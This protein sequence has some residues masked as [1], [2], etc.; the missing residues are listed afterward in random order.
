MVQSKRG[1]RSV[2]GPATAPYKNGPYDWDEM[3]ALQKQSLPF[4]RYELTK[5]FG[6]LVALNATMDQA[7][8]V[9]ALRIIDFEFELLG[10]N[11]SDAD[12]T[13][14]ATVAGIQ[15]QTDGG[16]TDSI[17]ILP[18]LDTS[19]SPWATVLW[20]TENQ[21]I[22]ECVLHT[23]ANIA[24]VVIWAGLK[25]TNTDVVITDNDQVYFRFDTVVANWEATTSIGGV[26]TETDTGVAVAINTTYYLKI[27]IDSARL[28]HFY[29]NNKEVHTTAALTDD[30]DLIPY[31]GILESTGAVKTLHLSSMRISRLVFE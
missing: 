19:F 17:I 18:H 29:I 20:G 11:A 3:I 10:N 5:Q 31:V 23:D 27:E 28:A 4:E 2:K 1:L 22:W 30:V 15:M 7:W 6:K 8:T 24:D 9:E 21:V 26:D 13:A 12:I 25:L 16:G 14:S